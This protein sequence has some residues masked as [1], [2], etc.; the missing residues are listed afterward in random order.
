M[1][2]SFLTPI[3]RNKIKKVTLLN[4]LVDSSEFE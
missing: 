1:S 2:Q 4:N 3:K